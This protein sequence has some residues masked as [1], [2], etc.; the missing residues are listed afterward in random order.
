MNYLNFVF[1]GLLMM[2]LGVSI[3]GS[4]IGQIP[5]WYKGKP[6]KGTPQVIPGRIEFENHDT[7][8]FDIAFNTDY[9][10]EGP[11]K[12][13][14]PGETQFA[15]IDETNTGV[16]IDRR[17]DGSLYPSASN[18]HSYYLGWTHAGDWTR[19]TVHVKESGDYRISSTFAEETKQIGFFLKF[20]DGDTIK[21][22]L[23]YGEGNWHTWKQF[24]NIATVHLD[25]GMYV[26]H[27]EMT[28]TH[29]NYDYLDFTLI[30]PAAKPQASNTDKIDDKLN[31]ALFITKPNDLLSKKN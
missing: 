26:M 14:R 16:N 23:D 24:D 17:V 18:P 22:K 7:G 9:I 3:S 21:V 5:N 4:S 8:G 28:I 10:A 13:Y 15:S 2:I 29:L 31:H 1:K 19:F 12:N 27:F 6:F 11:V 30:T 25:S 20:N